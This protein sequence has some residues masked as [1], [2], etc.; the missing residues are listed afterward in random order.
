MSP[1]R[2]VDVYKFL[3]D[4]NETDRQRIRRAQDAEEVLRIVENTRIELDLEQMRKD[5]EKIRKL[6][7]L[8]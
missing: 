2:R 5:N 6:L 1:R 7:K 8:R 4:L 3:T